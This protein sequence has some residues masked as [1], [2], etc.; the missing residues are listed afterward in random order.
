MR[1]QNR[2]IIGGKQQCNPHE[3]QKGAPSAK[4]LKGAIPEEEQR[5]VRKPGGNTSGKKDQGSIF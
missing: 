1:K 3:D 4:L 5:T 2:F